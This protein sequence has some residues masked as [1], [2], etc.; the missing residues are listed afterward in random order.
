MSG[1]Y[2]PWCCFVDQGKE[3]P[4]DA[5]WEIHPHS[6]QASTHACK[7]HVGNLLDA[8]G[9]DVLPLYDPNEEE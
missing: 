1:Q 3:C 5:E 7:D 6:S 8:R 9:G 4:R 2:T